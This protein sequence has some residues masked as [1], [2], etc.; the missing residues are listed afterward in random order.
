MR[1]SLLEI[2]PKGVCERAS[3]RDG[4]INDQ[5]VRHVINY[6]RTTSQ[7]RI[8]V[9]HL[10]KATKLSRITLERRFKRATGRSPG[11]YLIEQRVHNAKAIMLQEPKKQMVATA[12]AAGF[13]NYRQFRLNFIGETGLSPK[14]W[15]VQQAVR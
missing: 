6:I 13:T 7:K 5:A 9:K 10:V 4:H 11:A 14:Q 3:T 8:Q 15:L 1:Q 2:P 12:R